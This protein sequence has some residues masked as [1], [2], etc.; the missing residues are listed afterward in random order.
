[1]VLSKQQIE[2]VLQKIPGEKG[3]ITIENFL[4]H[5]KPY[6]DSE[7]VQ[8]V[9]DLDYI[10]KL[11]EHKEAYLIEGI[12]KIHVFAKPVFEYMKRRLVRN[13]HVLEIGCGGGELLLALAHRDT[14]GVY[15]GGDFNPN[16]ITNAR[17]L[18][19]CK[20]VKNC[21]F[22]CCDAN[23]FQTND[24]FDYIILCDVI[25]HLSCRELSKLLR[26]CRRLLKDSGE[27]VIHTPSGMNLYCQTDKTVMSRLY[28]FMYRKITKQP[29]LKDMEQIYYEQVHINV[30]SFRQWRKFFRENYFAL[31]VT[32]DSETDK[33]ICSWEG[34]KERLALNN[35]MLLIARAVKQ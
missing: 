27:I 23:M 4:N 3:V 16:A 20:D 28:F 22:H 7:D 5:L 11:E 25:E 19:E 21:V 30:K 2:Q 34:W 13:S 14:G 35:N 1:M 32:Y 29:Y 17:V 9:Y 18:A 15:V 12:Y 31:E 26:S 10:K 6:L 24:K 8:M 33:Q